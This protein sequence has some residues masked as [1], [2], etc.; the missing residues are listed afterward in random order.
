MKRG[1]EEWWV[2]G[3]GWM[4]RQMGEG[5]VGERCYG[6]NCVPHKFMC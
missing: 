2:D 1:I 4:G 3:W 6:L 5:W